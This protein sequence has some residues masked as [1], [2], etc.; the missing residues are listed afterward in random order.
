M[1]L[2]QSVAMPLVTRVAV[3]IGVQN[4]QPRLSALVQ[5]SWLSLAQPCWDGAR[6]A[7]TV[8]A[9]PFSRQTSDAV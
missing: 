7:K 6:A 5:F 9:A 8:E 4:Y 2:P 1:A 3:P